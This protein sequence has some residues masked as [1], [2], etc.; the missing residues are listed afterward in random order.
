[1]LGDISVLARSKYLFCKVNIYIYFFSVESEYHFLWWLPRWRVLFEFLDADNLLFTIHALFLI[2]LHVF[3]YLFLAFTN[4]LLTSCS[5]S[6]RFFYFPFLSLDNLWA[7]EIFFMYVIFPLWKPLHSMMIWQFKIKTSICPSQHLPART[8]IVR[9]D[10]C[11]C[12][13]YVHVFY[14]VVDT[15]GFQSLYAEFLLL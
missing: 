15:D 5:I 6:S 3:S 9:T 8:T 10:Q 4:D 1:M 11:G 2:Q 7:R 13:F 14:Q 12:L